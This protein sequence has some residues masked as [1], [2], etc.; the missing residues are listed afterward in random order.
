MPPE[1]QKELGD[2]V[3]WLYFP[4]GSVY[5][6]D[7]VSLVVFMHEH[8][9]L[10]SPD[11]VNYILARQKKGLFLPENFLDGVC[12]DG[13]LTAADLVGLTP[14]TDTVGWTP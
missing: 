5:F 6:A 14:Y 13:Y 1:Q 3:V 9:C 8:G 2:G 7:R 10:V 12:A 11:A 4:R